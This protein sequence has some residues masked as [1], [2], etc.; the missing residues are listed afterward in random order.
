[1]LAG[2]G[3]RP[4]PGWP[5]GVYFGPELV[6][7]GIVVASELPRER[8]TLLVRLMAAGPHLPQAIEEL[9]TLPAGAHERA[10]AQQILLRL[11]HAL[12][13]K[14]SR[15]REEQEFM[16]T[17]YRTWEDAE[18]EARAKGL[19]EGRD[20]GRKEGRAEGRAEGE[21]RALLTALRVRGIAVPDAARERILAEKNLA[22]LERWLEKAIVA[23]SLA[24]VMDE[25]S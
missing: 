20:E 7:I 8:A 22:Q 14:P 5:P 16:K 10:V 2:L 21:A 18:R 24:D 3:A 4:A 23:S 1:V 13:K 15:T 12:G 6:R 17:M 19:K 9:R 25:P 11:Q